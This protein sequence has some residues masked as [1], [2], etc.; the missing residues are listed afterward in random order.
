MVVGRIKHPSVIARLRLRYY[1]GGVE[2]EWEACD[3]AESSVTWER[4]EDFSLFNKLVDQLK[5]RRLLLFF[6]SGKTPRV[7]RE[8]PP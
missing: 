1:E 5:G 7:M 6:Q 2:A 3:R 4:S 8:R